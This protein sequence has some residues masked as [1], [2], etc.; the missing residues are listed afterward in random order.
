MTAHPEKGG[1]PKTFQRLNKAVGMCG[2]IIDLP[3]DLLAPR[4]FLLFLHMKKKQS[5][6]FGVGVG[7]ALRLRYILLDMN[8]TA[9]HMYLESHRS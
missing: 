9:A 8:K 5:K 7:L 2:Q 1:D 6:L 3:V 4:R